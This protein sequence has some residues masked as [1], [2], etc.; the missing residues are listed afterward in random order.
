MLSDLNEVYRRIICRHD[1]CTAYRAYMRKALLWLSFTNR[2]LHLEELCEAIVIEEGDVDLD[3]YSRLQDLLISLRLGQGLF[4]LHKRSGCVTVVYSL[5]KT[6]LTSAYIRT[7][8]AVDFALDEV[9]SN[10][11]IVR[12][13][14]TYFRFNVSVSGNRVRSDPSTVSTQSRHRSANPKELLRE[15]RNVLEIS[16]LDSPFSGYPLIAYAAEN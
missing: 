9:E 13:C 4:E 1:L 15:T 3:E 6:F 11:A 8:D 12:S 2:P 16:H 14:L 10:N 5:V 7:T